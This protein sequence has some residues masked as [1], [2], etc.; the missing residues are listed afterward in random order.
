[1]NR[2]IPANN[3]PWKKVLAY[4]VLV[5][6]LVLAGYTYYNFYFVFGSGFKA[7]ELNY[8]SRT[9]YVF[10][11]NEG[12]LI[13]VGYKS[14]SGTSIQSNEFR[15]CVTD[16]AVMKK[17]EVNSGKVMQLHYKQYLGTLPWRGMSN[18]VVD[19]ILSMGTSQTI[20]PPMP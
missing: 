13:Q 15:F 16:E 5:L 12:K 1:M 3:Q 9:G 7:G 18:Y 4:V 19:S 14:G 10:K 20:N 8:I 6:V 11:T 2:N 17:L